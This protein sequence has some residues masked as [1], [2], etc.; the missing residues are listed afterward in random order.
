[1]EVEATVI[2]LVNTP[3]PASYTNLS[4]GFY[5]DHNDVALEGMGHF[6]YK[7]VKEKCKGTQH[8]LKMQNQSCSR[9]LFQ[10]MQKRLKTSWVKPRML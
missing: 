7:W 10:D 5:S 3:L 1:M 6:F 8:L 9:S 2:C 4:L